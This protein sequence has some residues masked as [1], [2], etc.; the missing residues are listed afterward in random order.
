MGM[1]AEKAE[2]LK[3][4]EGYQVTEE[5]CR[6]GGAK[7]DWVFMHCLPRKQD[8]VDDEVRRIFTL[9]VKYSHLLPGLLRPP[10]HRIPRSGQ[11][12]VDDH[13]ALRPPLRKVGHCWPTLW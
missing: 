11:P 6:V 2:R 8:E 3:A 7:P 4:F 10:L 5:L 13:G 1:E 12:E 9:V